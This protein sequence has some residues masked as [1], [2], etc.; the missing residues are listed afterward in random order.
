MTLNCLI[1]LNEIC[2]IN[3]FITFIELITDILQGRAF[4]DFL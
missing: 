3:W 4:Y 1:V 2:C